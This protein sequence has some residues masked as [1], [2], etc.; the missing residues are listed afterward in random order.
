MSRAQ[1]VFD[2][3]YTHGKPGF[4]IF[5]KRLRKKKKARRTKQD[6]KSPQ[7]FEATN[8]LDVVDNLGATPIH[9]AAAYG[10]VNILRIL[11]PLMKN[12]N[13]PSSTAILGKSPID[14]A[15]DRGHDE[16]ARILQSYIK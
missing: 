10:D 7:S 6:I 4:L 16:F 14:W 12:P 2:L 11:A 3:N 8:N 9:A 13:V 15:N 1:S 5:T